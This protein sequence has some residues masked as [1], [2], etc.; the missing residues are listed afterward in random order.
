MCQVHMFPRMAISHP[1]HGLILHGCILGLALWR[2]RKLWIGFSPRCS[3]TE[4]ALQTP[5]LPRGGLGY[6]EHLIRKIFKVRTKGPLH[7]KGSSVD[8][9]DH[10]CAAEE[11]LNE[12]NVELRWSCTVIDR[13]GVRIWKIQKHIIKLMKLVT[14]KVD[15]GAVAWASFFNIPRS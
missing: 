1:T 11:V 6:A 10:H 13:M 12:N 5:S 15:R 8:H 2:S 7:H 14:I 4:L 3:E 9:D